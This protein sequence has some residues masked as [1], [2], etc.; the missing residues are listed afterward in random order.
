MNSPI[1]VIHYSDDVWENYIKFYLYYEEKT[2]NERKYEGYIVIKKQKDYHSNGGIISTAKGLAELVGIVEPKHM[3]KTI[4]LKDIKYAKIVKE[5]TSGI[6]GTG[7]LI[8]FFMKG[9]RHREA[10]ILEH[11]YR[12]DVFGFKYAE[13]S[14]AHKMCDTINYLIGNDMIICE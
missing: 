1:L 5:A 8:Q 4:K 6:F 7:G 10:K 14:I 11:R 13:S 2:N 3:V 12:M 9:E